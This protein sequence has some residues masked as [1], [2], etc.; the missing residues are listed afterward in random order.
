MYVCCSLISLQRQYKIP[1]GV[2]RKIL[3]HSMITRQ[4]CQHDSE[5]ITLVC[6]SNRFCEDEPFISSKI[7]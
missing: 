7:N 2:K 1:P 4:K 5:L 6:K 3:Y